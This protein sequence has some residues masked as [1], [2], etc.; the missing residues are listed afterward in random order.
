MAAIKAGD[1]DETRKLLSNGADVN[2]ISDKTTL[3]E[4]DTRVMHPS[5]PLLWAVIQRNAVT[6]KVLLEAGADPKLTCGLGYP[7]IPPSTVIL[8]HAVENGDEEIVR[9]LLEAGAADSGMFGGDF[10]THGSFMQAARINPGLLNILVQCGA[11]INS[12]DAAGDSD[13]HKSLREL[14]Q[15]SYFVVD[16]LLALGADVNL[17][18]SRTGIT[19]VILAIEIKSPQ[20]VIELLLAKGAN[21]HSKDCTR[22]NALHCAANMCNLWALSRLL[23]EN[24]DLESKWNTFYSELTIFHYLFETCRRCFALP[25]CH[26]TEP[27]FYLRAMNILVKAGAKLNCGELMDPVKVLRWFGWEAELIYEERNRSDIARSKGMEEKHI[28]E[29]RNILMTLNWAFSNVDNLKHLCRLKIRVIL[30]TNFRERLKMLNLPGVLYDYIL[31]K[32]LLILEA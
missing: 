11:A 25:F 16:R 17:P 14:G 7:C 20:I 10:H 12:L 2:S 29:I 24:I 13:L 27:Y 19:P 8:T 21:P 26:W 28:D 3:T 1:V 4:D 15:D 23:Q 5:C 31:M 6:V 22:R 32:D 18:N 9:H 30:K